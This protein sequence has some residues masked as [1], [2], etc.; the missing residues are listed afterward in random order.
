MIYLLL[1]LAV[2][3]VGYIIGAQMKKRGLKSSWIGR[4]QTLVIILLVFLMGSRIGANEQILESLDT[5]GL[6][7]FAFTLIIFVF[8]CAGFFVTRKAL[9]FDR[10]GIRRAG[11]GNT[12]PD[13]KAEIETEASPTEETLHAEEVIPA[14]ETDTS[15][16]TK[17]NWLTILIV[18]FVVIGI[19]AGY[20]VLPEAFM[21]HTGNLMTLTLCMLLI[22]IGMDVGTEGTIGQNFKIAGWRIF[23]F[24]FASIASMMIG[25]VFASLVLPMGV[26]DSLCVGSGLAWYSLAPVMLAEYSTRISAI[27]FMHNVFREI[28][29][30]LLVPLVAKRIG[31]IES[32][33]MPGSP[34]MDVCL[35]VIEKST[36]GD[37]AV[38]SFICG[39]I[40]SAAVPILISI[41][42]SF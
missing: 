21:E 33:S 16:P 37:V 18:L 1:Y 20:L 27:S 8:T 13:A 3:V 28:L 35:P 17:I 36:S 34:C 38:Y 30:M 26:Q 9:G 31:Y 29:G 32:Y 5:I 10:Y 2:T 42:M 22:T 39:A 25:S 6:I 11:K 24:P 15:K 4:L 7:A 41:F 19:L 23:V 14:E 12:D 40:L